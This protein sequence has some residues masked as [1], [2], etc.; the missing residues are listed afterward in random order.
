[1]V[2]VLGGGKEGGRGVTSLKSLLFIKAL[3]RIGIYND[4]DTFIASC[5]NSI[6]TSENPMAHNQGVWMLAT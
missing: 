5:I 3:F 2:K 4:D 6:I 1:M